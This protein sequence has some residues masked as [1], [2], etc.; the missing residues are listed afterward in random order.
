MKTKAI[1][2]EKI[3]DLHKQIMYFWEIPWLNGALC[4]VYKVEIGPM[5]LEKKSKCEKFTKFTTTQTLEK[6]RVIRNAQARFWLRWSNINV[7]D[8]GEGAF[9]VDGAGVW[10]KNVR[11]PFSLNSKLE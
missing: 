6:Q 8:P 9:G 3:N 4:K 2:E 7:P 11:F 5:V 10:K 1:T